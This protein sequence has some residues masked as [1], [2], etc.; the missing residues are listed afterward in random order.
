M[1]PLQLL[2]LELIELGQKHEA[3]YAHPGGP[4]CLYCGTAHST[5]VDCRDPCS[6]AGCSWNGIT[7]ELPD[8]V[9]SPVLCS[10]H[11]PNGCKPLPV[12]P[13]KKGN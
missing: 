5:S 4:Q 13:P 9:V 7:R 11:A 2:P 8:G 3:P 12:A 6:V 1:K 10:K